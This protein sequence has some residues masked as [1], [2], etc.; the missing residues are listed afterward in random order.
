MLKDALSLVFLI[1]IIYSIYTIFQIEKKV[2]GIKK[3][4]EEIKNKIQ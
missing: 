4:I 2:D 3:D 1:Y